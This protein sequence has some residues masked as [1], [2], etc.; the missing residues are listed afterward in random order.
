[1]MPAI[2]AEFKKLL[3]V[4]STYLITIFSILFLLFIAFYVEGWRLKPAELHQTGQLASDVYGG[5]TLSLLGAVVAILS[6]THEYRYNTIMYTLTATN[7]RSKV[8]LSKIIVISCYAIF[9]TILLGVLSPVATYLGVHA[10]GHEL[11]PQVLHYKDL[12]WRSLFYG[13]AYGMLGL[14]LATLIRIQVGTIVALFAIPAFIEPLLSQLLN[15]NAVYLPYSALTQLVGDDAPGGGSLA[16]GKA[17]LVF[18][19]YL[20]VAW[21]VAWYL[22]LRRDAN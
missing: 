22:F 15:K 14:V 11:V 5:L 8:L 9:F 6:M 3:S 10:H 18:C 17:A 19:S 2:R 13:W 16:P 21:A 4:R 20:V 12:I 7:S 1:M